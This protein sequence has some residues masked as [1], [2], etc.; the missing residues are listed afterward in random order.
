MS[1]I[2]FADAYAP[3]AADVR[4]SARSRIPSIRAA[5]RLLSPCARLAQLGSQRDEA[6]LREPLAL[7]ALGGGLFSCA[8]AETRGRDRRGRRAP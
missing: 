5:L 1:A 7:A 3:S 6:L 8:H 2:C 4:R